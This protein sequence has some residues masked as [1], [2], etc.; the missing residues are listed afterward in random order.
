MIEGMRPKRLFAR[1]G[2]YFV[3]AYAAGALF[4]CEQFFTTNLLSG[5][6][7]DP[8]TMSAEQKVQFAQ[9]ALGSGD[10]AAMKS[11]FDALTSGGTS[12][13]TTEQKVLA[14][15]CGNGALSIQSQAATIAAQW[16][17]GDTGAANSSIDSLAQN[18][19][20]TLAAATANILDQLSISTPG[21]TADDYALAA[22]T[23]GLI[24]AK[25]AGGVV[26]L[27]QTPGTYGDPAIDGP[28]TNA[29]NYFANSQTILSNTGQS[30]DTVNGI[31]GLFNA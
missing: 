6:R 1:L 11:A 14:V 3:L 18:I 20:A 2:V 9:A 4:G 26:N 17:A 31:A 21:I 15:Q 7:R 12:G 30:S 27:N 29:Q 8:A 23:Q 28:I 24:A 19:D 13:M 16:S 22:I 25:A 10:A 5:L